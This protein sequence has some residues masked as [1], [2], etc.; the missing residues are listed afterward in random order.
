MVEEMHLDT[1]GF[2]IEEDTMG[3]LHYF[4]TPA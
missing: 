1:G 4:Y 2:P 3:F